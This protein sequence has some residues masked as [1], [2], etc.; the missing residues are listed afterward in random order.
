MYN[1]FETHIPLY[2]QIRRGRMSGEKERTA[3]TSPLKNI[4][5]QCL[6]MRFARSIL[7]D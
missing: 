2:T 7:R 3:D 1:E 4:T 6:S 5:T